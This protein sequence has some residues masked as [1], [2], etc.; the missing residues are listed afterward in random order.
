MKHWLEHFATRKEAFSKSTMCC[1]KDLEGRK[2]YREASRMHR[3]P[4][5]GANTKLQWKKGNLDP[6]CPNCKKLFLNIT[7][8]GHLAGQRK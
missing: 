1:R 6:I 7:G 8:A 4:V 5:Q 2:V 3:G